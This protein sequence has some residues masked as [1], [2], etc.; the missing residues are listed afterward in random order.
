MISL[1]WCLPHVCVLD[2]GRKAYMRY[3]DKI[4][5][6]SDVS[7]FTPVEIFKAIG[8]STS[9]TLI[10]THM[11]R[12]MC[13]IINFVVWLLCLRKELSYSCGGFKNIV[14]S[15]SKSS[16]RFSYFFCPSYW[17]VSLFI[18]SPSLVDFIHF[19]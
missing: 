3:L 12:F 7:W 13:A 8:S 2:L 5:K 18:F 1:L 16:R 10:C 4:Y 15:L 11:H 17:R 14:P 6:Q 19:G 9:L